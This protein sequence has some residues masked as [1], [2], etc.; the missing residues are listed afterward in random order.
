M[1]KLL[2]KCAIILSTYQPRGPRGVINTSKTTFENKI[3]D[4]C[5]NNRYFKGLCVRLTERP[6][7]TIS[8]LAVCKDLNSKL[9]AQVILG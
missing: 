9:T 6:L 8:I 1:T 5:E 2:S 4:N 7:L 3:E